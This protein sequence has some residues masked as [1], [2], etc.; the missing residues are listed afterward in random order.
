M[1]R[2]LQWFRNKLYSQLALQTRQMF[3]MA[4]SWVVP[5]EKLANNWSTR[6][7]NLR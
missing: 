4:G 5:L 1:P 6:P 3:G 7:W 2:I